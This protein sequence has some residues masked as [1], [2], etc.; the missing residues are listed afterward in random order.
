MRSRVELLAQNRRDAP[1]GRV[2][3]VVGGSP[4]LWPLSGS[5]FRRSAKFASAMAFQVASTNLCRKPQAAS[6]STV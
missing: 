1:N 6:R 4:C 3:V 5:L 2:V